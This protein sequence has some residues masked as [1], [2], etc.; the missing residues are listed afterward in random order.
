[1]TDETSRKRQLDDLRD[2]N[3]FCVNCGAAYGVTDECCPQ[4]QFDPVNDEKDG[5]R[6]EEALRRYSL[7]QRER[8]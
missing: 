5:E 6:H 7:Q 2:P 1:M 3:E 4:C 8:M